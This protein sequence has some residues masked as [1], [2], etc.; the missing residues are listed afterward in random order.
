MVLIAPGHGGRD[1]GGGA[2]GLFREKDWTL[3]ASLHQEKIL[4]AGGH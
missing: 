2:C 3:E 4:L 1:P